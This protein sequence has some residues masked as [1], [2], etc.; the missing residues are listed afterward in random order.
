M[1]QYPDMGFGAPSFRL[2]FLIDVAVELNF[3]KN[4]A[5]NFVCIIS[6]IMNYCINK[7]EISCSNLS[8]SALRV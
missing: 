1:M 8:V 3:S 5:D 4:D 2:P 7:L 6:G